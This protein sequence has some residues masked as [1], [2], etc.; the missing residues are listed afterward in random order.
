[1]CAPGGEK[2]GREKA[3][4]KRRRKRGAAKK[5]NKGRLSGEDESKKETKKKQRWGKGEN[6]ERKDSLKTKKK[7]YVR[8]SLGKKTGQERKGATDMYGVKRAVKQ[9]KGS[10]SCA[11]LRQR[12]PKKNS[13]RKETDTL[14]KT[15]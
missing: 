10:S 8:E 13:G 7:K 6:R 5:K 4:G 3:G 12:N 1:L 11:P 2:P 15:K 9:K 14:P